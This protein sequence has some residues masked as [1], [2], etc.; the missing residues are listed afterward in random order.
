MI[1]P[2]K[3]TPLKYITEEWLIKNGIFYDKLIFE[4]G[5]DFSSDPKAHIK[6]RFEISKKK[7]I[8]YFIEDDLE[9]AIKLS[10]MCDICF[11]IS[12]PYNLSFS[13]LPNE[14]KRK[15]EAFPSN[16]IRVKNWDEISQ[17]LR[18]LA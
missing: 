10:Y 14:I 12:H 8:R 2:L 6:N 15:R 1:K 17:H 3:E 16:I 11:L 7:K 13:N 5:N 9:K 4:K 18:R